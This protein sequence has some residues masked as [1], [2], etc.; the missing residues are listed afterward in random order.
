M[1]LVNFPG[2][3]KSDQDPDWM[4]IKDFRVED[5]AKVSKIMENIYR[6]I[7]EIE[8]EF[9]YDI[10]WE[11]SSS[12]YLGEGATHYNRLVI[13]QEYKEYSNTLA[14][15]IPKLIN[16]N[17]FILN[18]SLYVPLLFLEKAPIDRILNKDDKKDK[19]FI[20]INA[21][22]NFTF[23]FQK[24]IVQF[25]LKQIPMD[26]FFRI[27]YAS[28]PEYLEELK[29]LGFVTKIKH[30]KEER[31]KFMKSFM[32]FYKWDYFDDVDIAAWMDKYLL[33]DY[34][35]DIF[36]DFYGVNNL[37]DI[38]KEVIQHEVH[39]TEIDMAK[40]TNRRVVMT[41]YLIRP[42]LEVYTR[43][44]Y[45][46]IDKKAQNFLPSINEYAVMTTGFNGLLHRG[47]L[48]DISNPYALPL[49]NK[50]SQD[51]QI[52]KQGRLPKSWQRN[53]ATGYGRLCPITVSPQNMGANLVFTS[54]TKINR[55]GR[56]QILKNTL[57]EKE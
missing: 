1:N 13:N 4:L 35:R 49:I 11:S 7:Q 40:L 17:F 29:E 31:K 38:I 15:L 37:S 41:E 18:G 3:A 27:F 6:N 44:L 28:D 55:F 5:M 21:V 24:K 46:V 36:R 39:E 26:I 34:Y 52:I 45:G 22:F 42:L 53:D 25:R 54:S 2:Y 48:Y 50:V 57:E 56:V 30:T 51:I 43:L 19:I 14:T 10:N 23:D 12:P 9:K 47:Q 16:D 32:D 20:N 33:L 8:P